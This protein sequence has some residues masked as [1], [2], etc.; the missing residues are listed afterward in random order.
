MCFCSLVLA[1][2]QPGQRFPNRPRIFPR[3]QDRQ[4]QVDQPDQSEAR[5]GQQMMQNAFEM[6]L[7]DSNGDGVKSEQEIHEAVQRFLEQSRERSPQRFKRMMQRFDTDKDQQ[8]SRSE[9]LAVYKDVTERLRQKQGEDGPRPGDGKISEQEIYAAIQANINNERVRNPQHYNMLM[10]RFDVDKDQII[11]FAEAMEMHRD[12]E[13]RMREQPEGSSPQEARQVSDNGLLK[14][15][16]I[17]GLN[18]G[19]GL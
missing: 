17:E 19:S 10:Q 14:G 2:Q 13:K 12:H 8:I 7:V 18:I 6:Q 1:A 15:I 4:D 16:K 5:Q 9:A 11:S 3:N